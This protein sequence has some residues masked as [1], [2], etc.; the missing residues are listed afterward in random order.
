MVRSRL[1]SGKQ[2]L[3]IASEAVAGLK[4]WHAE[5][6]SLDAL[7]LVN[8]GERSKRRLFGSIPII[9]SFFFK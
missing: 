5:L 2:V 8:I 9:R 6:E 4:G 7:D 3:L 1:R